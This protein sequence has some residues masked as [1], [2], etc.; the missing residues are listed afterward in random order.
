MPEYVPALPK[1]QIV[2]Q[3]AAL[4]RHQNHGARASNLSV[5]GNPGDSEVVGNHP[6]TVSLSR[7]FPAQD[8]FSS[9]S[10]SLCMFNSPFLFFRAFLSMLVQAYGI[11]DDTLGIQ[12]SLTSGGIFYLNDELIRSIISIEVLE[13]DLPQ[14]WKNFVNS[15]PEPDFTS[16]VKSPLPI[17]SPSPSYSPSGDPQISVPP[18]KPVGWDWEQYLRDNNLSEVEDPTDSDFAAEDE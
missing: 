14:W 2:Y 16:P 6:R 1:P 4:Y 5:P 3:S 13:P 15:C 11:N 10:K 9:F 7:C 12:H 17:I 8:S 18:N